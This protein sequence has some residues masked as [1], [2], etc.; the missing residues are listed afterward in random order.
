M[1]F[2][3]AWNQKDFFYRAER[4]NSIPTKNIFFNLQS[5]IFSFNKKMIIA[6]IIGLLQSLYI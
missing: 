4:I 3:V 6:L 1:E 2:E 5:A